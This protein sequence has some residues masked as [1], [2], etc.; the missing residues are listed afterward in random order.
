M[1]APRRPWTTRE[2]AY[3]REHYPTKPVAGI[4][5]ALG[6][7]V[8]SIY[9]QAR[10][11]GIKRANQV[12]VYTLDLVKSRCQ[13]DAND[14]DDACW[15]WQG[16]SNGGIPYGWHEGRLRSMRQV[17]LELHRGKKMRSEFV[18]QPSCGEP[19]CLNPRHLKEVHRRVLARDNRGL[20]PA[21]VRTARLR[22]QALANGRAKLDMDKAR[23]IRLSDE[24][25]AV[26]A[27]RYGV[28]R[29]TI[30]CVRRGEH[31][32]GATVLG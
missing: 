18:V 14:G 15:L 21:P 3:L 30:N 17:V 20:E 7:P 11:H 23:E 4:A 27:E 22:R 1:T 19:G 2:M 12:G 31:W 25:S 29:K 16:C 28:T 26:L 8:H 5:Q 32:A 24:G 13:V 9:Q 6:R 10:I